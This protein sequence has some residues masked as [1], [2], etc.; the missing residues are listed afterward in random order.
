MPKS[1]P[2]RG[3]SSSD[4]NSL[5]TEQVRRVAD[6]LYAYT[7]QREAAEAK[8]SK[9]DRKIR[10]WTR[11]QTIGAWIYTAITALIFVA[12]ILSIQE[13]RRASD[14]ASKQASISEDTE[15]RQLRAY[16]GPVDAFP[17]RFE[18]GQNINFHIAVKNFGNTPAVHFHLKSNEGIE[19]RSADYSYQIQ[20]YRL[21]HTVQSV[22]I[23]PKDQRAFLAPATSNNLVTEP[24]FTGVRGG[25]SVIVFYG[26]LYYDDSFGKVR[27]S[28][29][30]YWFDWAHLTSH[31]WT[32][33][34]NHHGID[35]NSEGDLP[36]L[37]VP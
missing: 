19:P 31:A 18:V 32:E 29:F 4:R 17:D 3:S 28:D 5:A 14:A 1:P 11:R 7:R 25:N 13:A 22:T 23:Y 37:K 33:C 16:I 35:D 8:N 26:T 21:Q 20:E 9:H 24:Q 12:G 30:C 36:K 6:A 15:E 34:R 27:G 2:G 10:W